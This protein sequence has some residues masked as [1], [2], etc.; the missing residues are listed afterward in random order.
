MLKLLKECSLTGN[1]FWLP[2]V[3]HAHPRLKAVKIP[4]FALQFQIMTMELSKNFK[5]A[6]IE[7][8][9]NKHWKKKGYFNSQAG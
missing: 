7:E 9:W 3:A 6:A 2:L 8:K 4:T 5:P 1:F